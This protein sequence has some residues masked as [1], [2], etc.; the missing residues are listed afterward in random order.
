LS[1]VAVPFPPDDPF[2]GAEGASRGPYPFGRLEPRGERGGLA[3]PVALLMRL[4][5]NPF[6]PYLERR[7]AEFV[8]EIERDPAR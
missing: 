2:Y 1:H 3:V 6:F 8:E 4:R 5:Y 7:L